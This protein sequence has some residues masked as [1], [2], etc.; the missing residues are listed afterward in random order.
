MSEIKN[1]FVPYDNND[2]TVYVND[3]PITSKESWY[4]VIESVG[5]LKARIEQL[6]ATRQPDYQRVIEKIEACRI[7][8]P[9]DDLALGFNVGLTRAIAILK[10]AG[11]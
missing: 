4:K 9:P 8:T 6:E 1:V 3:I 7:Q 11:E 2:Y 5:T 10:E